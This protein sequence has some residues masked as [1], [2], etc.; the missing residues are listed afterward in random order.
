MRPLQAQFAA[1]HG[2][3][4]ICK[5]LETLRHSGL[6]EQELFNN[7]A[8][9]RKVN[10]LKAAWDR[11]Q[12][13]LKVCADHPAVR[14]GSKGKRVLQQTGTVNLQSCV[15]PE[16]APRAQVAKAFV[17]WL[18]ALPSSLLPESSWPSLL[19]VPKCSSISHQLQTLRF[20]L[21]KVS[22]LAPATPCA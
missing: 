13:P 8:D 5:S 12:D 4:A 15:R 22:T 18:Q 3:P 17:L 21:E 9:T 2:I 10:L 16:R 19:D 7:P 1:N 11:G 20:A 14:L 6:E